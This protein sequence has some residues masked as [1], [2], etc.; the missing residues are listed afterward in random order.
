MNMDRTK[1]HQ[2]SQRPIKVN[3]FDLM[4]MGHQVMGVN[5]CTNHETMHMIDQGILSYLTEGID[6]IVSKSDADEINSIFRT[7][8]RYLDR[9][10]E[11]DFPRRATRFHFTD[12]TNITATERRGNALI[13][14]VVLV[15][16]N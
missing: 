10:S 13:I 8:S 7:L 9:Q 11:N 12:G 5:G 1:L 6:T 14:L 15:T 16:F 4:P 3:V 2:I